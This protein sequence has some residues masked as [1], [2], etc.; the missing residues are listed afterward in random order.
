MYSPAVRRKMAELAEN[1]AFIRNLRYLQCRKRFHRNLRLRREALKA[2]GRDPSKPSAEFFKQFCC[3]RCALLLDPFAVKPLAYL[4]R[5]RFT[6]KDLA[7][8]RRS[9]SVWKSVTCVKCYRMFTSLY[10]FLWDA[11]L[12]HRLA[13]HVAAKKKAATLLE[14]HGSANAV[15][16]AR[17]KAIKK[18]YALNLTGA[19]SAAL[20]FR[21]RFLWKKRCREA[22]LTFG[23]STAGSILL[24]AISQRCHAL[25]PVMAKEHLTTFVHVD[26]TPSI[27]S[28][29]LAHCRT[30]VNADSIVLL[31]A[32]QLQASQAARFFCD[33]IR[34]RNRNHLPVLDIEDEEED[35][36]QTQKASAIV[37]TA[38][39]SVEPDPKADT[40]VDDTATSNVHA[41]QQEVKEAE[42]PA[43]TP[44]AS[45]K[46]VS[47]SP[48]ASRLSPPPQHVQVSN[49]SPRSPT[50]SPTPEKRSPKHMSRTS[51]R[52]EESKPYRPLNDDEP[53]DDLCVRWLTGSVT[54]FCSERCFMF[55]ELL[56]QQTDSKFDLDSRHIVSY[57]DNMCQECKEAVVQAL[58]EVRRFVRV[59]CSLQCRL[60][61]RNLRKQAVL[62]RREK[63][64]GL[65]PE[66]IDTQFKATKG[67]CTRCQ[68]FLDVLKQ[69]VN[70]FRKR[71]Q[72]YRLEI[73]ET[74]TGSFGHAPT[75]NNSSSLL[76]AKT[77]GTISS[78]NSTGSFGPP[79]KKK[80]L[81]NASGTLF[82]LCDRCKC[83]AKAQ[84]REVAKEKI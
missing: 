72:E 37:D 61:W 32:K 30:V 63:Y 55:G 49:S 81:S 62:K 18:K 77:F 43:A 28:R 3:E 36:E 74:M 53:L 65:A 66:V 19:G 84:L 39:Q 31:L 22:G 13:D 6:A 80:L 16:A 54:A 79:S 38:T 75:P 2:E 70:H 23:G 1:E 17:I 33:L 60:R 40:T 52:P 4:H 64:G 34:W 5:S 41:P 11:A 46:S 15:S 56:S 83:V 44:K 68:P 24:T 59:V 9:V 35:V 10:W 25:A 78:F 20:F 73:S 12:R 27:M 8:L 47:L 58:L 82:E 45:P 21:D 51:P 42:S 69:Q 48:K 76:K 67:R 14:A 50:V 7:V 71:A 57:L 29:Y 26:W